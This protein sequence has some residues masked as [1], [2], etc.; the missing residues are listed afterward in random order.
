M[1]VRILGAA[2]G[3]GFPQWNCGCRQCD[4]V[5]RGTL[6]AVARTQVT[7][8]LSG[9]GSRWVLLNCGPEIR[10]QIES[11]PELWPRAPRHSPIATIVLTCGDLDHTLGLLSLRENH[12]L[13]LFATETVRHGFTDGNALY[14]TL[15]RFP[16]QV[17]WRPLVADHEVP[18]DHADAAQASLFATPVP[19][20]GK[21]PLHRDGAAGRTG[22]ETVGLLV[23]D[24]AGR[25]LAAFP[26]AGGITPAMRAAMAAADAVLFDGTF[27]SEDELSRPGLMDRRAADMAHLPIGGPQGSLALLADLA[28][29]HR[30]YVHVNNT[31]PILDEDSAER[32]AVER[33]GWRVAEDGMEIVL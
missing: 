4:G 27:W 12:P 22:E 16:G 7:I 25:R 17:T 18:L 13:T 2:A 29:A 30:I 10:S 31:N 21:P 33:A 11:F 19:A 8:A 5:R 20:P 1:R 15:E 23:R 28:A 32:A 6:R 3:G 24:R 9:D 14:R 26:G